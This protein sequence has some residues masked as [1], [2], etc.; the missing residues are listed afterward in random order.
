MLMSSFFIQYEMFKSESVGLMDRY[1]GLGGDK[2]TLL[3]DIDA[4]MAVGEDIT[5]PSAM[6]DTMKT[7]LAECLCACA[8]LL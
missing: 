8:P 3:G 7:G 6:I 2:E 5:D 1:P 4:T